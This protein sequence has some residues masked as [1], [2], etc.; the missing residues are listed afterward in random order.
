[1]KRGLLALL[2]V[3]CA[4]GPGLPSRP[5]GEALLTIAGGVEGAPY[6]L[7]R[8]DLAG[9]PRA[10]LRAADPADGREST[11]DGVSLVKLVR[12]LR[13]APPP[14]ARGPQR[15]DGPPPLRDTLVLTAR[16]GRELALSVTE[17]NTYRPILADRRDGA[18]VAPM[19]A[20]P[21]APQAGLPRDARLD[22]GWLREV[23][24]A[25]LEDGIRRARRLRPPPGASP[26]AR[27]GAGQYQQRC[28]GC[29][30]L[31][32]VGGSLGPALDASAGPPGLEGMAA[33]LERH[34]GLKDRVG[35]ELTPA[36]EVALQVS[37]YLA[38]VREAGPVPAEDSPE[39]RGPGAATPSP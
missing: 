28:A 20:W 2:A 21:P 35:L 25:S 30:R 38:A 1:M 6:R 8:A 26:E 23:T 11:F 27:L 9:L 31:R 29:H 33:F 17:I 5:A 22:R 14:A 34:A 16:D 39:E 32:E 24:T 18:E 7:G 36:R 19:L 10:S 13:E 12:R 4:T 3:S 37:A 15:R